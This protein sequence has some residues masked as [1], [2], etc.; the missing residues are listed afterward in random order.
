MLQDLLKPSSYGKLV[1]GLLRGRIRTPAEL[2]F[3]WVRPIAVLKGIHFNQGYR[4]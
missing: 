3:I 1:Q 2:L 4:R